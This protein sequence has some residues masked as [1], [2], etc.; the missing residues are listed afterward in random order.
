MISG[1]GYIQV[2]LTLIWVKRSNL[3]DQYC[4]Q[5]R[6]SLLQCHD[7]IISIRRPVDS[8]TKPILLGFEWPLTHEPPNSCMVIGPHSLL[9]A[10]FK[11]PNPES[12]SRETHFWATCFLFSFFNSQNRIPTTQW[13]RFHC[14]SHKLKKCLSL[15]LTTTC[16]HL[17]GNQNSYSLYPLIFPGPCEPKL[18]AIEEHN[19]ITRLKPACPYNPMRPNGGLRVLGELFFAFLYIKIC[20]DW[21]FGAASCTENWSIIGPRLLQQTYVY[22]V[23]VN[24]LSL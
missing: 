18:Q 7:S 17:Q 22:P 16:L 3:G 4:C 11:P 24:L 13:E 12:S 2:T 14:K 5:G 23:F 21:L 9:W 8:V 20:I 19:S 6:K 10:D 15:A 1:R